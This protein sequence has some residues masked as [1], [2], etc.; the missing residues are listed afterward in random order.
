[1]CMKQQNQ[2]NLKPCPFCGGKATV[3]NIGDG[4]IPFPY[5]VFCTTCY[6]ETDTYKSRD[7]AI[8]SW[9]YRYEPP[10]GGLVPAGNERLKNG[11]T[12]TR[13]K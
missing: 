12:N 9:N 6:V 13:Q 11:N 8:A 5:R 10:C 4:T 7:E 2:S 1:M 3:D